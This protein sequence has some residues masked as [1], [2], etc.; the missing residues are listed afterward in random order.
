MNSSI[1]YLFAI[2]LTLPIAI[3]SQDFFEGEIH[4]KINY[5]IIN[6]NIPDEFLE[7]QMGTSFDAFVK[8]D[9]YI[10]IYDTKGEFGTKKIIVR[11]DEGFSY[12]NLRKIRYYL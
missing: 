12:L 7:I 5:E 9:K 1:K 3:Y 10:M 4:Y 11:L 2:F 6:K 8:E